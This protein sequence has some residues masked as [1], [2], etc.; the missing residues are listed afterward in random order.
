MIKIFLRDILKQKNM[1]LKEL[2]KLT[3]ISSNTLSGIQNEKKESIH[4]PTLDKITTALDIQ[5]DDLIKKIGCIYELSI[6]IVV[7]QSNSSNKSIC[8]ITL[9]EIHDN[10]DT[11]R[12]DLP[13]N[14]HKGVVTDYNVLL[15]EINSNDLHSMKNSIID[16]GLKVSIEENITDLFKIISFLISLELI[17]NKI[18]D[19]DLF[20]IIMSNLIKNKENSKDIIQRVIINLKETK[21]INNSKL[22]FIPDQDILRLNNL[23]YEMDIENDIPQ[24]ILIK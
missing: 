16:N 15:I 13:F 2:S 5:V 12:L 10:F 7:E 22:S 8:E 17:N 18:V 1:S 11:Q 4:F 3:G 24:K 20:G 9:S 6:N 23:I 14:F 19:I 21:Y